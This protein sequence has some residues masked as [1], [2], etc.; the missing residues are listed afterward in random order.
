M[1]KPRNAV[2]EA[3]SNIEAPL[4]AMLGQKMS[5]E[6]FNAQVA[7][8][9]RDNPDLLQCLETKIGKTTF[10]GAVLQAASLGLEPGPMGGC[11]IVPFRSR[12]HNG[13][14]LAQLMLEYR[15]M[16]QLATQRGGCLDLSAH[17]V[18]AKDEFRVSLG[19]KESVEHN[20]YIG[21]DDPG[22]PIAYYATATLKTGLHKVYVMT[23]AKV[24]A[25]RDKYGKDKGP[26]STAFDEMAKKTVLKKL[27]KWLPID[28]RGFRDE[29]ERVVAYNATLGDD[30]TL[31]D[32]GDDVGSLLIDVDDAMTEADTEHDHYRRHM[33]YLLKE[34]RLGKDV[35]DAARHHWLEEHAGVKSSTE[36]TVDDLREFCRILEQYWVEVTH[37]GE[38][39]GPRVDY[40]KA[41]S[42]GEEYHGEVGG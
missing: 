25:H 29:P 24:E 40:L 5:P 39:I 27:C 3:L 10:L 21:P 34:S 16:I 33:F 37:K 28:D 2:R 38:A 36:A 1:A 30:V 31:V 8:C 42:Q 26:W 4:L 20:P 19:T 41:L 18:F 11:A 9:V 17:T 13:A 7:G 22:Q 35:L 6:R 15:G 32:D 12:K 14:M 23:R